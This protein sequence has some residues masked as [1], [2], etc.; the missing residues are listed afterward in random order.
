[1]FERIHF[2]SFKTER[3]LT[4]RKL[5]ITELSEKQYNIEAVE[6]S[7]FYIWGSVDAFEKPPITDYAKEKLYHLEDFDIFH[8]GEG[9]FTERENF[10]SYLILYT[11]G[12]EGILTYRNHTYSLKEGD[13]AFI[14]CR[15]YHLY[16]TVGKDNW[17][18]A[19][20]HL[21]GPLLS[22]FHKNY[23]ESGTPMFSEP[24][25]GG[26]QAKL[27]ELLEI[28]SNP[29]LYRDWL[30]S[31]CIDSL[32]VHILEQNIAYTTPRK[33]K[34]IPENI[35]ELIK[36]MEGNY[37]SPFTLDSISEYVNISKY[38]LSREFKRY[39]GFSPMD[40]IVSLRINRAKFLLTATDMSVAEIAEEVGVRD[41]NNFTNLFKARTGCT[42]RLYRKTH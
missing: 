42:P 37:S 5:K 25:T 36:Y 40:Y 11:Y 14:D 22:D 16:K 24:L 32:L 6:T 39:T 30:A 27:E 34:I 13:G 18:T 3:P 8:Y 29:T 15:D 10:N 17:D 33:G 7:T 20:L 12:G 9:S 28:Y 4:S 35:R 26:F 31:S 19:I 23:I 2:H 38:H 1:M 21:K 41:I